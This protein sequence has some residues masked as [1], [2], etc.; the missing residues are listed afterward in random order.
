MTNQFTT[1]AE[2]VVDDLGRLYDGGGE[3]WW[4]VSVRTPPGWPRFMSRNYRV[5]AYTEAAAG[6]EGLMRFAEEIDGQPR[7][8]VLEV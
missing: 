2:A 6:Q 3:H 5:R 7:S 1:P 8:A 4:R